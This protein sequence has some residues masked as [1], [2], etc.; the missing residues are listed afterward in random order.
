MTARSAGPG[1]EFA[2]YAVR[3]SGT[4]FRW[5]AERG[6]RASEVAE[7]RFGPV[8]TLQSAPGDRSWHV[9]VGRICRLAAHSQGD[10]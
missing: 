5:A 9:A 4:E 8:R 2:A 3:V 6:G 7:L 10:V 1:G